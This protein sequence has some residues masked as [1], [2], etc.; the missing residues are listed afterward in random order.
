MSIVQK[1][2]FFSDFFSCFPTI[3]TCNC[4][5]ASDMPHNA[6]AKGWGRKLINIVGVSDITVRKRERREREREG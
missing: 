3:N 5:A 4:S 1:L 6:I 2:R